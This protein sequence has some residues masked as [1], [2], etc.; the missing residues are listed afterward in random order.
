[1]RYYVSGLL[2]LLFL[3]SAP[4]FAAEVRGKVTD[5][6]GAAV[7]G[8]QV[9]LVGQLGVESQ[10]LSGENG[11][12]ALPSTGRPGVRLVVA[13]PGFSTKIL[14][15]DQAAA[16]RLELAAR[17]DAIEVTAST[18]GVLGAQQGGSVSLVPREELRRRN[19]PFGTDFLRYIPGLTVNQS[20]S[21][22]G[23]TSLFL[24]GGGSSDVLVQVDGAPVNGFGGLFDF[25][26]IP[27]EALD[28]IEVVRGPQSA[29]YGPYANGGVVDFVTRKPGESAQLD[30]LAEGGTYRERRFGV[31]GSGSAAG[32]GLLAAASQID[33]DGPVANSDYRNSSLLLNV[34][35][36]LARQGF[37]LHAGY[38]SNEVGQPGPWG[39]D[40]LGTY[41]GLDLISR[42]KN[43]FATYS[44]K[45]SADLSSRVRQEVFGSFFQNRNG[46]SSPYGFS[47][48]KDQRGRGESRTLVALNRYYTAAFGVSVEREQVENV[49]I[50]DAAFSTFPIRRTDAAFYAE[51]RLEF[52]GRVFLNAGLRGE[53]LRTGSM[54]GDGFS[55]P[56]FPASSLGRVNPKLAIAWAAAS[57][58]RL[59]GSFGMGF[60]PPSGFELAFTD[61]PALAPERTRSFDAG[62]EQRV[63]G[64]LLLLDVTW[65][66]NRYDDLIVTLGGSLSTLSHYHS[67]NLA[68]SRAQ[69]GEFTA[70][71][72]PARSVFVTAS[73]TLLA[74]RILDLDGAGGQ[75]PLPF[76]VGQP[77]TRR[78]R[79]SGSVVAAFSRGRVTADV[80]GSFRG[81]ALY[82][83]PSYGAPSGLFWNPGYANVGLNLNLQVRRGL[84]AYGNLR[85]ALNRRY[86]E[87]FGYPSLHL[88]F[89][90]GLKWTLK[91][92]R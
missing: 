14:P 42:G 85:N 30:L 48:N 52:G 57:G 11:D 22:G 55:R 21:P 71:V 62:I 41:Q 46:Y 80:T 81:Q 8:A 4:G 16:V 18:I 29:I 88:N 73:Y 60:R 13:A 23:V 2:G 44:G 34:S 75:A 12:F 17:V 84:S 51:N 89:V 39:K 45:Y 38:N 86:E 43:N 83:E 15:V 56:N 54:P 82:E 90:A 47:F 92:A 53:W 5:P 63:F 37:S 76:T 64:N 1:M 27:A 65:F 20:G 49:F 79:N 78:P 3:F 9:S 28:H 6:G 26:H 66:H 59:H 10:T 35:R 40:P 58:T 32:F 36:R 33:T 91:G 70:S 74:T 72:R 77:L 87:I 69:G 7:P 68:N 67:A 25:A 31:T 50:T 61:N 19:E 24:R